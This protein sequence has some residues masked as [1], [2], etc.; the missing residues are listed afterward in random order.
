MKPLL[1]IEHKHYKNTRLHE[2]NEH[3]EQS[4]AGCLMKRCGRAQVLHEPRF[5]RILQPPQISRW[6]NPVSCLYRMPWRLVVVGYLTTDQDEVI[7]VFYTS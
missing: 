6:I 1:S 5:A 4:Q 7:Q 2:S 3:L